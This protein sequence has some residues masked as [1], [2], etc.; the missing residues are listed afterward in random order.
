MMEM[1]VET[2]TTKLARNVTVIVLS[3][4]GFE[5]WRVETQYQ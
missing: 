2:G 3:F 1:L 4:A 5:L